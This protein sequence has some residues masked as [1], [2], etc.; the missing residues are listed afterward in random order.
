M[1]DASHGRGFVERELRRIEQALRDPQPADRYCQLYAA[2]Q[3]LA[4]A[5]EPS[6]FAEPYIVICEGRVQAIEG[7]QED[8]ASRHTPD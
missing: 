7:I 6:G 1:I 5:L 8:S 4:W 3:A 2:Q